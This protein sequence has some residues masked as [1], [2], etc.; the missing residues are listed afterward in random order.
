MFF[1]FELIAIPTMKPA[2]IIP[3]LLFTLALLAPR[4]TSAQAVDT[5]FISNDCGSDPGFD[6]GFYNGHEQFVNKIVLTLDPTDG[7]G[8]LGATQ[9]LNA[10][11]VFDNGIDSLGDSLVFYTI[12]GGGIPTGQNDTGFYFL[13]GGLADNQFPIDLFDHEVTIHWETLAGGQFVNQGT[14][15]LIPTLFQGNCTFDSVSASATTIG[16]DPYFN[17]RVFN[18]NGPRQPINEMKFEVVGDAAGSIRPS[19]VQPPSGWIL[20]SVT[21][22]AAYFETTGNG[23]SYGSNLGGFIVPLRANPDATA[24]S[25]IWAAS[26][27]GALIDRD[28]VL[29]VPATALPCSET[30]TSPDSLSILNTSECNFLIN[31][32]NY[33]NGD[34]ADTVSPITSYTLN[35]LTPGV[36]WS[37]ATNP[38]Q[39]IN[40]T[41]QNSG[42]GVDSTTLNFHEVSKYLI[43]PRYAQPSGTIWTP[44]A[45]IENPNNVPNVIVQWSDSNLSTFLSS[46]M[47]TISCSNTTPDTFNVVKGPDCSYTLTVGNVHTH[48]TSS[49]DAILI[50]MPAG[51]GTFPAGATCY[52][53]SNGWDSTAPGNNTLR[54]T[55]TKGASGYLGTGSV[56]KFN[57][58]ID[59]SQ[60]DSSWILSWTPID[61]ANGS[62]A[63][64][65]SITVPGC[66]PPLVCDS[67]RHV[68]NPNDCSDSIIVLNLR[69]GGAE[70][71]S[72]IVTPEAGWNIV[73]VDTPLFWQAAIESD[74]S[75]HFTASS[76][77]ITPGLSLPFAVWYN[78]PDPNSF[79]V[80]V[81]TYSNGGTVCSNTQTLEC[82]LNGVSPSSMPQSLAVSVVPNPMNDEADIMLTTGAYDRVQMTLMDVLGRTSKTVMNSAIAAGD[83]DY[84]L[85]VSQLPP[86]TYYLRVE[87][88]GTTLTK[89]L[90]IEH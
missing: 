10:T 26:S 72:V 14:L 90:V 64:P 46:G 77:S 36:F 38:T 23:I 83:H 29:N 15:V 22:S 4:M 3:L 74:G 35:I 2:R 89:K 66:S 76:H 70:V 62:I 56:A 8:F 65:Y 41:W 47:D 9:Y 55:N 1:V 45:S 49:I 61:S 5:F 18:D 17:F 44:K 16:C 43:D 71:D 84:T 12:N 87:A 50:T 63:L 86:G 25:W 78:N 60:I 33:H 73:K 82:P 40:G 30:T 52:T 51:S 27:G 19:G 81:A 34:N 20:D 7:I 6:F 67:I 80:Q 53:A 58:C 31:V 68:M 75:A 11:G 37:S 39:A 24:F 79:T 54:F 88:S 57:F 69:E 85:D 59:P 21:E 42:V 13:L 32:K 28:T 48:K